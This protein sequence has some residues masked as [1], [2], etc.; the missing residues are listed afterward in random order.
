M[1][2]GFLSE[3]GL[4]IN[5]TLE[6]TDKSLEEIHSYSDEAER[7]CRIDPDK[8]MISTRQALEVLI[9]SIL[10]AKG[11]TSFDRADSLYMMIK[12]CQGQQIITHLQK[13][14]LDS[15]RIN[16]NDIVHVEK[17]V[18]KNAYR[19][20]GRHATI[21]EAVRTVIDLYCVISD[22]FGKPTIKIDKDDLPIGEY[23]IVK[24]YV[25]RNSDILYGKY[26]Y[27][28]VKKGGLVPIYAY[29]R[30]F[31]KVCDEEQVF[32]ERDIAAQTLLKNLPDTNFILKGNEISVSANNEARYVA[33]EIKKNTTTLDQL[34]KPLT[35][36]EALNVILDVVTGLCDIKT[37]GINLHH[38]GINPHCIFVN[39]EGNNYRGKLGCFETS[40]IEIE[41]QN[42][43]SIYGIVASLNMGSVFVHPSFLNEYHSYDSAEWEKG[44]IYSI[45]ISLLYCLDA[46]NVDKKIIDTSCF[47]SVYSREFAD[48]MFRIIESGSLELIPSIEEFKAMLTEEISNG[49]YSD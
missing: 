17:N 41:E 8:S 10:C 35:P 9:S 2:F 38:R 28:G 42:V 47:Y 39:K 37:D 1:L 7:N 21:E 26:E 19:I 22:M 12:E 36:K 27:V 4:K 14:K 32:N 45:A 3:K 23:E 11:K 46:N 31:K 6:L 43:E 49:S 18:T 30:P 5:K 24:K 16:A 15:L 29:I 25:G 34:I 20:E 33:Y 44:D 48:Y 13:K 40:K